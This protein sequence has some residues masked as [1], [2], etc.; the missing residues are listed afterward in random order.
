[1]V[2]TFIKNSTRPRRFA[3]RQSFYPS[4]IKSKRPVPHDLHRHAGNQGCVTPSA[5]IASP[6]QLIMV[7]HRFAIND[8]P[9]SQIVQALVSGAF[10]ALSRLSGLEYVLWTT[11]EGFLVDGKSSNVATALIA[12]ALSKKP[13]KT[14]YSTPHLASVVYH[15]KVK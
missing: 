1:M 11:L 10:R 3:L 9:V 2:I 13:E 8:T 6:Q 4:L 5:A 14:G 12:P 15:G 7:N